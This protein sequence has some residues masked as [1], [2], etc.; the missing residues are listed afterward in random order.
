MAK[1]DIVDAEGGQPSSDT[2]V[3]GLV[4]FTTLALVAAFLVIKYAHG[5]N[6][7]VGMFAK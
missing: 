6:Y 7:G 4:I 1:D 5:T 2:F 3:T